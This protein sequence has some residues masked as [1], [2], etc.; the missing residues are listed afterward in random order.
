VATHRQFHYEN[1]QILKNGGVSRLIDL[2]LEENTAFSL[3]I[4]TLA[5]SN[6]IKKG[7]PRLCLVDDKGNRV[8]DTLV[9][10][11]ELAKGEKH[12]MKEGLKQKIFELAKESGPELELVLQA[13]KF[14]IK[15]KPLIGYHMPQI[16]QNL[17]LMGNRLEFSS[18]MNLIQQKFGL[19]QQISS[20]EEKSLRKGIMTTTLIKV[21]N[22][23]DIAKIFNREVSCQS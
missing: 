2:N 10:P 23:Y 9:Q 11:T 16:L 4:E 7:V 5:S 12:I 19:G 6:P 1:S 22:L 14:L 13:V 3:N 17:G 20:Q 15:G 8:I 18:D 21:E